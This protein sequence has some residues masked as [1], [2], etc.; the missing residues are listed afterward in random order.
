MRIAQLAP[1]WERV[2][3]PTL[4][5]KIPLSIREFAYQALAISF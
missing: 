3:P 4:D 2:S 5:G 1:R